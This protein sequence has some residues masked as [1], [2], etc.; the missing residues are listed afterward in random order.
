MYNENNSKL[1]MKLSQFKYRED[2]GHEWYVQILNI[3]RWSFLQFSVSWND[4]PSWPYI[5]ITLG[6]N[7]LFSILFWA[8]K[9]GFDIDILSRTWNWDYLEKIEE[10]EKTS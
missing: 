10:N 7:G 2:F 3:K 8:Y 6:S 9:F 5:Q 4:F 1:K